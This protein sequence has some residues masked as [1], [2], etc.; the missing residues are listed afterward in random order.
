MRAAVRRFAVWYEGLSE[1][2]RTWYGILL[3][4]VLFTMFLYCLGFTSVLVRPILLE[5]WPPPTMMLYA[6]TVEIVQGTP[7]PMLPTV[8]MPAGARLPTSTLEPTPTQM[9]YPTSPPV[10]PTPPE[11]TPLTQTPG[12]PT[13]TPTLTAFTPT[14]IITVTP[15]PTAL[16]PTSTP[17]TP[18][19][20]AT[21]TPTT[22]AATVTPTPTSTSTPTTEAPTATPAETAT[23][24][25]TAT[26]TGITTTVSSLWGR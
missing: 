25:P 21:P 22:P 17:T 11:G 10:S 12:T 1:S 13:L 20:T 16:A 26:D 8:T 9:P 6:P 23:A 5:R 4:V 3:I 7:V 19:A 2:R 14:P 24:T 15:S 18:A